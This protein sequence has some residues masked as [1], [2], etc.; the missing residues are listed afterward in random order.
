MVSLMKFE[1]RSSKFESI[2][3]CRGQS[4]LEYAVL[5]SVVVAALIAMQI[6]MKRGVQGKLR[7]ATD[8]VG[9]QFRPAGTDTF[10]SYNTVSNSRRRE[11]VSNTGESSSTLSADETQKK[12]GG[13]KIDLLDESN[14]L[15]LSNGDASR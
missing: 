3:R 2:G 8:Q 4:T 7:D 9:E 5:I 13:E 11:L 10:W 14:K 1:V 6:Y 15:F 12:A